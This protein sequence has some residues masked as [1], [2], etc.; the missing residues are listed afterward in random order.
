[1][2]KKLGG[3]GFVLVALGLIVYALF[4]WFHTDKPAPKITSS[5][6]QEQRQEDKKTEEQV[7]HDLQAT[8]TKKEPNKHAGTSEKKEEVI[9][10]EKIALQFIRTIVPYDGTKRSVQ[11]DKVSKLEKLKPIL[12]DVVYKQYQ[13]GGDMTAAN[14]ENGGNLNE[15]PPF[16]YIGKISEVTAKETDHEGDSWTYQ[17][18]YRIT[19]YNQS[20]KATDDVKQAGMIQLEKWKGKIVITSYSIGMEPDNE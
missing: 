20:H 16:H 4:L 10:P 9:Q 12:Q 15:F 17:V 13:N 8:T 18:N 11:E 7:H 2:G 19:F 5:A 6:K 3:I 14:D 1:M